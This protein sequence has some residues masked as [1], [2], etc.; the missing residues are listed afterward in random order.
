MYANGHGVPQDYEEAVKWLRKA[1]EQGDA[2]G[3][4]NLGVM[5][6][7]G[8]GVPQDYEEAVKWYRKAAEQGDAE[9]KRYLVQIPTEAER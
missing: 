9:A 7:N 8:H 6:A 4:R 5:Y 3:Q 2:G 1:V